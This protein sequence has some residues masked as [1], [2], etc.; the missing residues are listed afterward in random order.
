MERKDEVLLVDAYSL[1]YRAFFA[2][3]P[4]STSSGRPINAAYGFQ[5]MLHR[6]LREEKPSHVIACFDA[7]IPPERLAAVPQY[8]AQRPHMPDDLRPQFPIVRRILAAYGIPVIEIEG[9]EADDCIATIVTVAAERRL[10]SV[11][12]S[13]DLDLLQL[14]GPHCIVV[15]TKRGIS[16]LMRY[17]GDAVRERY[18]L[19]PEQLPDYRGLK[20]DPSDNLPGVPGIGEKTATKLIAQF[21]SLDALLAN[22]DAVTPS[23]IAQ[24]LREHA[25]QA[26]ACRDVSRAKRDLPIRPDWEAWRYREPSPERL[27][28]LYAELE[29]KSLLSQVATPAFEQIAGT[30]H[31]EE[32]GRAAFEEGSYRALEEPSAIAQALEEALASQR[33]ALTLVP[34]LQSWRHQRPVAVALSWREKSAAVVRAATVLA[35][36][37]LRARFARLLQAETPRIIVYDEKNLSGYLRAAGVPADGAWLDVMLAAGLADQAGGEPSLSEALDHTP[38][39]GAPLPDFGAKN[40]AELFAPDAALQAS[41]AVCADALLRAADARLQAVSQAGLD[42]VLLEIEQPLAPVLAKMEAVG[43]RIDRAELAQLDR[44]LSR[45]IAQTTQ[46][47]YRLAGEEFNINSP[48]ALGVILF[49]KLGLPLRTK[50]KGSYPTGAEILAPLAGEFEIAAKLLQYRE[51]SKLKSTYVDAL[52]ALIDPVTG[53]L[54]TTFH[55]LGAATGRLSSTNPNLQNI[56]V[57]STIG[58]GIRRAFL[59]ATEGN[60]LLAADYSQIELRIFA[61]MS[62]DRNFIEAFR[63]GDDIHDFTARAVFGIPQGERVSGAMRRRAKAVNFGILYGISPAGLAQS[64]GM[65]RS[66][67]KQFIADYFARF[68]SIKAF[69]DRQL[70]QAHEKGFVTTIFGRRRYLPDLRSRVYPLRA[71]AER[72][73]INAPA[74]GTAADL[75][76]RAMVR[77]DR[78]FAENAVRARLALQ[79]HDELI[80]DTPPDEVAR[81]QALVREAMEHAMALDV[82]IVVDFKVGP[83]WDQVEALA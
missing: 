15:V 40:A 46:D 41:W 78:A 50:R 43:F 38:A 3:P 25:A 54:H 17:D 65:T 60:V 83:N 76:K 49:E 5:R 1:V 35:R 55:Q 48:K 19:A 32:L 81:V 77:V 24:L 23:R 68:P 80:F 33:V 57:R 20:G 37:E 66:E 42:Q 45:Q 26:R 7:G 79:V 62:Q 11:I 6:M 53:L 30:T 16:D 18:G 69:I 36:E 31:G 59:P 72:M 9:E 13:G 29:F 28:Q 82:P 58:R 27:A 70:A 14:V 52:P 51:V 44:E 34:A 2:L 47:I 12:V 63:R 64:A 73:A 8:K 71:A 22:T 10:D 67:A 61:H 56:P 74:Q 21:G 4:L 39:Q 75:I